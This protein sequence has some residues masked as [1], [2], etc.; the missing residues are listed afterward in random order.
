MIDLY[1]KGLLQ[2]ESFVVA[3]GYVKSPRVWQTKEGDSRASLDYAFT[4]IDN[5]NVIDML[6][7]NQAAQAQAQAAA[8]APAPAAPAPAAAMMPMQPAAPATMPQQTSAAAMMPMQPAAPTQAAL[9]NPG[10][11]FTTQQNAAAANIPGQVSNGKNF[12]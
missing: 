10:A 1:N 8:P 7:Q 12:L 5:L 2:V 9:P 6:L 3:E 4:S 11:V